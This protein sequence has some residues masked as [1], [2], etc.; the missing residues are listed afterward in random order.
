M[1]F[2]RNQHSKAIELFDDAIKSDSQSAVGLLQSWFHLLSDKRVYAKAV[3]YLQEAVTLDPK[4][5]EAHYNLALAYL[6]WGYRQ[7][8]K[9]AAQKALN[10]DKNYRPAR[11]LLEAIE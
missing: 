4:F 7:E 11:Q 5:K 1:P 10:I 8:A 3:N 6:R 9:K 2:S